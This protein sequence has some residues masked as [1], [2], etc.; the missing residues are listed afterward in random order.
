MQ[1]TPVPAY[2]RRPGPTR[3]VEARPL[4]RVAR[5]VAAAGTLLA[6]LAGPLLATGQ[7]SEAATI[8]APTGPARPPAHGQPSSAEPA[9]GA[10]GGA[11]AAPSQPSRAAGGAKGGSSSGQGRKGRKGR[12]AAPQ[13][14]KPFIEPLAAV[15]L[16]LAGLSSDQHQLVALRTYSEAELYTTRAQSRLH[17]ATLALAR[18]VL[19][20]GE[21]RSAEARAVSVRAAAKRRVRL[22]TT[23][24]YELGLTEYT[25]QAAYTG[26]DLVSQE[27]Q[28]ERSELS[29]VAA[30]DEGGGWQ[31]ARAWL[32]VAE[33][34]LEAARVRVVL[35]LRAQAGARR[36]LGLAQDALA[37]SRTALLAA[38]TWATVPGRAPAEPARLLLALETGRPSSG[39]P[40]A[41][42]GA[43]KSGRRVLVAGD[44]AGAAGRLAP[45]A[46]AL[47]RQPSGP[48]RPGSAYLYSGG[49]TI[50]GRPV[51]SARE[52]AQWFASTQ[53]VANA[54]V[55]ISTL[56]GYY[57]DAGRLTGVRGDLAF[58]QS[59]VETG[60]FSFPSYGQDPAQYNNFAGIGACGKCKHGWKFSSAR[61]GVL[62][63][64]RLLS[65][66]A[67]P[68]GYHGWPGGPVPGQGVVGCCQT[69]MSL[70]GVWASNPNYGYDILSVY[71]EMLDWVIGQELQTSGLMPASSE[72]SRL[73]RDGLRA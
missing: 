14:A 32:Q 9:G 12:K 38:R 62:A 20:V 36:A 49:P 51:L 40:G 23:A 13:P 66:Y 37:R 70:G 71:K 53:A 56:V 21:A 11:K 17:T 2:D 30:R 55:P 33:R 48:P 42:E 10:A 67:A 18:A 1:A 19:D 61:A 31:G 28:I 39:G 4:W 46:P 16:L 27:R 34:R 7:P 59:V 35:A 25:G 52:I 60:G 54:T 26:T 69:W 47:P 72:A 57:M 63:Q 3:R 24:L 22:Y 15:Q 50:L 6:V 41:G 29:L 45:A 8:L 58:A 73:L 64:E 68:A 65:E 43:G 5:H 44:L